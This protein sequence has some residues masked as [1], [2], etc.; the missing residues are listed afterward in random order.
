MIGFIKLHR[1]V[2]GTW[3]HKDAILFKAWCDLLL[4][5]N[6]ES[7]LV[8]IKG[9]KM[10]CNE[11]ES[12]YSFDSWAT[13]F[14]GEWNKSKVRR[15]FK[16]LELDNRISLD[17][18]SVTTR[19]T[20]IDRTQNVTTSERRTNAE[21]NGKPTTI[22]TFEQN[23]RNDIGTQ[24]VTT[25]ERRTQT[26]KEGRI[27]K[28]IYIKEDYK[29]LILDDR[30]NHLLKKVE[31][32]DKVKE[33]FKSYGHYMNWR[34]RNK[35]GWG[36]FTQIEKVEAT[37]NEQ[38]KLYTPEKLI[39]AIS[40]VIEK[41]NVKIN[42]PWEINEDKKNKQP[43]KEQTILEYYKKYLKPNSFAHLMK[44]NPNLTQTYTK[45][46]D[47][48]LECKIELNSK[49]ET[50]T[51]PLLYDVMYGR[52]S[53]AGAKPESRLSVFKR[54]IASQNSFIQNKG[55]LK[56]LFSEYLNKR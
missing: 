53:K 2:T 44:D 21:R 25:S 46:K 55:D 16:K 12:L 20:I 47:K 17:N 1:E 27:K 39:K 24:N 15:F 36:N 5:V 14:G 30:L 51:A 31:W 19:L 18:E 43:Q 40:S 9:K 11:N 23:E 4:N 13:I 56:I 7:K 41:G 6:W 28:S 3:I 35:S 48:L 49:N 32:N 26:T 29:D 42:V 54:F 22:A 37:F 52:F 33:A 8:L 10:V 45:V 50:L 38:L 34:N